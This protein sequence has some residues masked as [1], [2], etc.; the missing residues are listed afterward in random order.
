MTTGP[1]NTI[2]IQT[3]FAI[4]NIIRI[5]MISAKNGLLEISI[6]QPSTSSG[7][8]KNNIIK[9]NHTSFTHAQL[10]TKWSGVYYQPDHGRVFIKIPTFVRTCLVN[11]NA[12]KFSLDD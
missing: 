3:D 1:L 12:F 8:E 11:F 2:M 10:I 5:G 6:S 9:V 4:T 7:P